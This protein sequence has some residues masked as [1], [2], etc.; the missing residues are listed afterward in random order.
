[1]ALELKGEIGMK[2]EVYTEIFN[3]LI[4]VGVMEIGNYTLENRNAGFVGSFIRVTKFKD[5]DSEKVVCVLYP[6]TECYDMYNVRLHDS[7][8]ELLE[9]IEH[10][11]DIIEAEELK[12]R[13]KALDVLR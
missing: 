7:I 9:S 10:K 4:D 6:S 8:T 12:L 11:N 13:N 5:T 2:F 1:M 3:V